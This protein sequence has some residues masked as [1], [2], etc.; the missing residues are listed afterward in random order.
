MPNRFSRLASHTLEE[1]HARQIEW[2]ELNARSYEL[3]LRNPVKAGTKHDPDA[4]IDG[5]WPLRPLPA[6]E[7]ASA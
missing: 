2:A 7:G 3:W 6:A 1:L 4:V 5:T